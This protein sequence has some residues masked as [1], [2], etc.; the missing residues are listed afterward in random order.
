MGGSGGGKSTLM[1]IL[2]GRKSLGQLGGELSLLGE[3]IEL[4]CA[5]DL[6]RNCDVLRNV[7]A[8]IP[9]DEQVST[10]ALLPTSQFRWSL[11]STLT[12]CYL[13]QFF[14][15]Q[16]PEEAVEFVANLKLGKDARGDDVRKRHVNQ[17]LD[18]VGIPKQARTRAIGGSLAGGLVIRGLSGGERKRLA[19]ACAI[20]MK[21]KI[22]FFVSDRFAL[23]ALC[24][25]HSCFLTPV[26][27]YVG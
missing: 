24:T 27:R 1:D 14:P 12:H 15:T 25:M 13:M 26:T 4:S 23:A 22:L 9:Q 10:S 8:Y 17:L 16:T 5:N 11:L 19:L 7:A 2:S 6:L 3:T 21:P 18:L 20:A